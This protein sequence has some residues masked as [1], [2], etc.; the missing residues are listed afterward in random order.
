MNILDNYYDIVVL[1]S[2]ILKTHKSINNKLINMYEIKLQKDGAYNICEG[3][4]DNVGH[5]T[6]VISILQNQ[7]ASWSVRDVV[8][9]R[10]VSSRTVWRS[11]TSTRSAIS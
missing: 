11:R 3:G 2:G 5:G 9:R 6:A 10:A 8:R 4:I 7:T 1:D